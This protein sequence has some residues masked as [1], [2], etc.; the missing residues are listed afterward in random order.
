MLGG[1]ERAATPERKFKAFADALVARDIASYRFDVTGIGLS[2]GDFYDT[3]TQSMADDLFEAISA[4]KNSGFKHI[5]LVGHSHAA[6]ALSLILPKVV[7][8][9]A[10]LIA[11]ATNQQALLRMWFAQSTNPHAD[12]DFSN[13]K[14]YL[15]EERYQHSLQDSSWTDMMTKSHALSP[16]LREINSRIDYA[17]NYKNVPPEKILIIHGADDV[18]CPR[19][20]VNVR[21]SHTVVVEGGNHDLEKPDQLNQWLPRAVEFIAQ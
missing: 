10:V 13:Y 11:P 8:A 19:E 17:T 3:T 18:L 4:V 1:F 12:I 16:R 2:D 14:T 21:A 15:D 9:H 5:S 7:I 6:C 20:S